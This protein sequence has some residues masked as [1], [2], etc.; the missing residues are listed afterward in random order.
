MPARIDAAGRAAREPAVSTG[1]TSGQAAPLTAGPHLIHW[2]REISRDDIPRVG[3]KG[4]NLG[5]MARAGLPVPPAFAID[6]NAHGRF[7]EIT[8]LGAELDERLKRIDVDDPDALQHLSSAVREL[9]ES[10][11]LPTDIAE[12]IADAYTA[13]SQQ[14]GTDDVPV[15]V[16][17]SATA[18]D[19]AQY[20]FAGMFES[21]LNVRGRGELLKRVKACWASPFHARVLFYRLKQGMPAEMPVGHVVQAMV[22][23]DKAGVLFTVDP[24][25]RDPDRIV[26]EA[27]W[28]LGEVVVL[29]QVTPD[30]YVLRR[31]QAASCYRRHRDFMVRDAQALPRDRPHGGS[32]R[33][34][35]VLTD[36][37]A[38]ALADRQRVESHYG[39]RRTSSSPSRRAVYRRNPSVTTLTGKP[40]DG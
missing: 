25:T 27:A 34:D 3:G 20:S 15:A 17:S 14:V 31:H 29:G 19:T 23:S 1:R 16:R 6:I 33:F 18:E 7:R 13:L 36:A 12:E 24:A 2:L 40:G 30:R 11:P 5:E 9:V 38:R 32:P 21:F 39:R 28:G 8:G 37:G 10:E 26:I 4:A 22:N 35:T